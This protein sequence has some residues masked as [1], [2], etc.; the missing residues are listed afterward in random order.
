MHALPAAATL[1][2][3]QMLFVVATHLRRQARNIVRQA[4]QDRAYDGINALLT[5]NEATSGWAPKPQT[6]TP[7][8]LGSGTA[9]PGW[10]TPFRLLSGLPRGDCSPRIDAPAPQTPHYYHSRWGRNPRELHST[11]ARR[12]SSPA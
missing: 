11:D 5:H 7:A 1:T 4:R 3:G 12:G 2:G 8:A 9:R 6:A 10:P